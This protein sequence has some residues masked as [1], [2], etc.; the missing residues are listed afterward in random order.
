[1]N[2]ITQF[3]QRKQEVDFKVQ[4]MKEFSKGVRSLDEVFRSLKK[5][6]EEKI[7][8]LL[9]LKDNLKMFFDFDSIYS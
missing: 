8:V 2:S 3:K 4:F 1:M 9:R 7:S 6:T 5:L